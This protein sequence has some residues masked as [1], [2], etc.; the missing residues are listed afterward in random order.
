M[1]SDFS[2]D[3]SDSSDPSVRL[4]NLH[5]ELD[6]S[7]LE[8]LRKALDPVWDDTKVE[9]LIFDMHDLEFINSKGIGFVVSAYTHF[10]KNKRKFI[11]V[12]AQEAVMDVVS[13]VGLTSI[14]PYYDTLDEAISNL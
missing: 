10:A 8:D 4:A 9:A 6:E 12:D 2:V 14:I 13:L 7:K 3:I 1:P 5:G 11:L